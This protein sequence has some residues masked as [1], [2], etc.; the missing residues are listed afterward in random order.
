VGA[1]V[2]GA[3]YRG[4]ALVRSLGRRGIPVWVLE[5]GDDVLARRSR[6]ATAHGRLPHD[7]IA[8]VGALLGLARRN[9][10]DRWVLFPTS[11]DSAALI[12]RHHERLAT[13]YTLATP[14]WNILQWAH[15]KRLT[16][17]LAAS[18]GIAH[19]RV[20]T[21]RT[22]AEASALPLPYPVI[23]KPAV[24]EFP[25]ALAT[26]KA[27]RTDT[28]AE[29][30][31]RF[32]EASALVDPGTLLIQELVPG[33]GEGQLSFT[34]LCNA[35]RVLVSVVA[36]R[37]RQFPADFGRASTFVETVD[38]T[39]VV[40]P[41]TRLLAQMAY[42]GLVEVEFKRPRPDAEPLLLDVNPRVWGWHGLCQ[43][44]GVDFPYLAWLLALGEQPPAATATPGVRWVRLS[45]DI[46]VSLREI[47]RGR[48][49]LR[50]YARSLR[51]PRAAAIYA[52]DDPWPALTELPMLAA[53][54]VR[55]WRRGDAI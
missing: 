6:Y 45:T 15:D 33:G 49:S 41:A 11:D 22:A 18:L 24:K 23:L 50:E 19:P 31:A 25:N 47:A 4:L 48:L 14:P 28:P 39:A 27:W 21:A 44:A 30:E 20:W 13:R 17:E 12:A 38:E 29:L 51:G 5:D 7:E 46:P 52:A 26:A 53:T 8:A 40:Q 3:D 36:R 34:A 54:A 9:A 2:V 37:R 32:A 1:V 35:G 10:L 55:R 42:T 16:Y 43:Q